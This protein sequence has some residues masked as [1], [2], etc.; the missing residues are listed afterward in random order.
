MKFKRQNAGNLKRV[1]T[2]W[3]TPRGHHSAQKEKRK[4]RSAMPNIGYRKP[5]NKRGLHPSGSKEV[6]I[7]SINDL[8][9]LT[10][11]AV[12]RLSRMG[13]KKK[14]EIINL[15]VKKGLR[16]INFKKPEER[17]KSLVESLKNAR[18]LKLKRKEL[19]VKKREEERKKREEEAKK[20]EQE[21]KSGEEVVKLKKKGAEAES[22]KE[23][24]EDE[25]VR[26]SK[27]TS[28]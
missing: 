24:A 4:Y 2:G 13:V 27:K 6:I 21:K 1:K 9:G 8:E 22:K 18:V 5:K 7:K 11:G 14:V 3:R 23:V 10:K 17:V 26:S 19:R 25:K 16:I 12:V 28:K 20:K 15:C